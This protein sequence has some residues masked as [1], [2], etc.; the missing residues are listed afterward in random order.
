MISLIKSCINR[1][2]RNDLQDGYRPIFFR[3]FFLVILNSQI[4]NAQADTQ[5]DCVILVPLSGDCRISPTTTSFEVQSNASLN[6]LTVDQNSNLA[7]TNIT[8]NGAINPNQ[9]HGVLIGSNTYPITINTFINNGTISGAVNN[10]NINLYQGSTINTLTNSG[11]I[12]GESILSLILNDGQSS[13]G[14]LVNT[15]SGLMN[16]STMGDAIRNENSSIGLIQNDGTI[17]IATGNGI[18]NINSSIGLI[19]N[20]GRIAVASGTVILNINSSITN[21]LNSGEMSISYGGNVI[22]NTSNIGSIINTSSGIISVN[23][24]GASNYGIANASG[25]AITTIINQGTIKAT[26][27]DSFGIGNLGTI[28]SLTNLQGLGN[29]AGPLTYV[30]VLPSNYKLIINNPNNFGQLS[31]TYNPSITPGSMAFGIYNTSTVSSGTYVGVLQG[32]GHNLSSYLSSGITGTYGNYNWSFSEEGTSGVWDLNFVPS[33]VNISSNSG[34]YLSNIGIT[35]NPVFS[36]GRLT[37]DTNNAVSSQNYTIASNGGTIDQNGLTANFSGVFSDATLGGKLTIQNSGTPGA[38]MIKLT[39]IN[40]YSGGTEVNAGSTLSISSGSGLGTGGLTLVGAEAIPA[41]LQV[42]SSTTI[43]NPI[44]VSGESI[45]D[46]ASGTT[47][48]ISS[49]IS[50][51]SSLGKVVLS[52]GGVLAL[53]NTNT[54]TGATSIASGST[55]ALSGSGSIASSSGVVNSGTLDISGTTSGSSISSLSG[56]GITTIGSKT[57]TLTNAAGT[58]SGVMGGTGGLT[59]SGGTEIFSGTNTFTGATSIASGS[60]VALSGNGSIASS[61]GVAN[62]GTLDISGTTTGAAITSLSGSG[63]TTLGSKTLTLTNAAGTYSGAMGGTGG[64]TISSGT[65]TLS[66]TNTYTGTTTIN[67]G[68]KLALTGSGSISQSN[69]IIDNGTFDISGTTSGSIITALSGSGVTILGS[70]TLTLLNSV[71]G[72]T[73][74]FTGSGNIVIQSGNQQISG[75]NSYTGTTSIVAGNTLTLTG[76]G[77]IASSSGVANNGTLDISGTTTGAAITSLS[78]SGT[79]TLGSKTLT[80]TNAAGTYSGVMGGTGG[81]TISGGT[82]TLSG[83]NTFTGATSIASGSTVALS[84]SGSIASSSGVAN[85]G[86]LNISGT[87]TGAAIASLSGSGATTLGSKTLT[88]TNAAGTYSGAM[89]GTGGLTISGGTETLSGT[90]TFTGTTIINSGAKLALTGSGSISQSNQI[91]DNGTFDISGTTS[92][93]TITVLSGSGVTILGSKTL[94]LLNSSTA[95]TGTFIG[96]GNIVIQSGNQQ[97]SGNNS[98]T[99]TTSIV[100]GNTLTLTGSGSIASSS[101]VVNSGTLDISGTTSGAAITSLSGSGTTTLGSKTLTLTNAANTYSGVMSGTGGLNIAG[102]TQTLSGTNTFTGSTNVNGGILNLSG[103]LASTEVTV[104]GGTL[105]N[106][107]GGLAT[108]T[109]L[110]V[111]SGTANINSN[112]VI[113]K[114]NGSGGAVGVA[115]GNTLT[116]NNGGTYAGVINGAGGITITGGTQTLSGTNTLSG[117]VTVNTG[118]QLTINS[119]AALGSGVL[120]LVGSATVPAILSVSNTTTIANPITVTADP[121]FN[122]ATGT[123]TTISSVITD[124]AS[125]GEV[126]VSGGGTIALQGAN[127]YTG[128]TVITNDG[129]TLALLGSGSVA[130][131]SGFINNSNFNITSANGNVVLKSYTQS[132]TG[133]LSM[134]FSPTNN[135]QVNVSGMTSLGGALS[136]TANSG[137]YSAGKYTLLTASSVSGTFSS[138]ATNLGSYTNLGYAL[139]YDSSDVYLVLTPNLANTKASLQQMAN[140]LQ[141]TYALQTSAI[142]MG[143]TYDCNLFDENN[144][145]LS[146]GGRYTRVNTGDNGSNVLLI[147]AYKLNPKVRLG[148]YVDQN[149]NTSNVAS[150]INLGNSNPLFGVFGVWNDQAD[151]LGYSMRV[152]AGYGDR[153]LSMTRQVIGTS[154]SGSGTTRLN[155]QAALI[156]GSYSFSVYPQWIA[157]PYVGIRYTKVSS[158]VY[159]EQASSTVTA[160]LTFDSLVQETTTSLAGVKLN[161]NLS[162]NLSVFGSLG[163]EQDLNNHGDNYS[164]TGLTGLIP[165]NFNPSLQKTRAVANLGASYEIDR[166]QRISLNAIYRQEA[167]Q[168]MNTLTSLVTYSAG[169]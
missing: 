45:F 53:T 150:G 24:N 163:V 115:S 88:L 106:T 152:A 167:F 91:I 136:L 56:S 101:G 29:N 68:A 110:T 13:I 166:A 20:D 57:L 121:T 63:T 74:T 27:T 70:K 154:E 32:F 65:E 113:A 30:G 102:G 157:S 50:D 21:I 59:I 34:N 84:G 1:V 103:S 95:Y 69:Q 10:P 114:L 117:V 131:S 168:A 153:D 123:T 140:N 158:S 73:G 125:S 77:S 145:C 36:G 35:L 137:T 107:N 164:A 43:N 111:N 46:I 71:T 89:G 98:Y 134:N 94:T 96:S 149:L 151:Q 144:I 159:S 54:Y 23:W 52:G 92:G 75:N 147:G 81:L 72:Y 40:T 104:A 86:T 58:Y 60:T 82:E 79:T 146:T 26:G 93:T 142:N 143:L 47:T 133:K 162:T 109:N 119:S 67:S 12:S 38:G 15:S 37:V 44:R 126:V 7:I 130:T 169:F 48:S 118:A 64:L 156:T 87:T 2:N 66:G 83:T 128:A 160:P 120:A 161:G 25:G 139:T 122:I 42:T 100:A 99:G 39:G 141:G 17:S 97:V 6:S 132:S 124:G 16:I 55:V 112:Q 105:T 129:S 78:G 76:S 155:T 138:L 165:I 127:T 116:I 9:G 148:A 18:F 11:T 31:Y 4:L 49:V 33:L 62:N 80:L 135:Q 85:N 5:A 108:T 3:L 8:L 61:S 41:K 90:N 22:V 28:S 19:Q 14:N 51:S